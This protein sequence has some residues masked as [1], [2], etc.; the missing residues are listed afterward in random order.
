MR[1]RP[2]APRQGMSLL[3]VIL[4]TTIFL[5]SLVGLGQLMSICTDLAVETEMTNRA[6]QLCQSKMNEFVTGIQALT[7]QSEV[8]FDE[9]PA[10]SWSAEC[11]ADSTVTNLWTVTVHVT[12]KK[13][14]GTMF[15]S[16]LNQM[17]IDPT[18]KG[19][20]ETPSTSGSSSGS[21]M[22][23]TPAGGN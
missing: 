11:Q 14:D 12:R 3:E 5:M 23:T 19:A 16:V 15:E 7:A 1:L 18:T 22:G 2:N 17:M 4:A 10:W 6:T 21:T 20:V 8:P 9:D 13:M